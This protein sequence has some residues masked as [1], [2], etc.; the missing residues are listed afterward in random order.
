MRDASNIAVFLPNWVGDV[1]M[2]TPALTALRGRFAQ[3]RIVFIGKPV[4]LAALEG[5]GLADESLVDLSRARPRLGGFVRM[6]RVL[7]ARK[8]E[9]AVLLPN[10]FHS[11]LLAWGGGCGRRIGYARDARGWMLTDKLLPL[12]GPGGRFAPVP[13]IDYYNAIAVRLGCAEPGRRMTLNVG[14]SD[15]AAADALLADAGVDASRPVVMLNP[16][17]AFGPSKLWP[18]E[19]YAQLADALVA[20]HGAQ[21]IL[22]AAPNEKPIA[23][24]VGQAMKTAPAISFADRDNTLGLL[25]GLLR[26]S[27][28]LVTNDTGARHFAAAVGCGVVTIFGSTDPVWAEINYPLERQ[29]RVHVPCSPC[30]SKV[31]RQAPGPQFHQC[32]QAVTV[33]MVLEAVEDL[34][35]QLAREKGTAR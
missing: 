28:L 21:I 35:A 29:V 30:Q 6:A 9:L 17:A 3:S 10:S 5:A 18:A 27:T 32:M 4:A 8:F 14:S 12:R 11:A 15:Q 31:C 26:R 1:V 13:T 2:A 20:R 7:R 25:K 19:R 23:R 33:E 24:A 34:L 22:N 16:G